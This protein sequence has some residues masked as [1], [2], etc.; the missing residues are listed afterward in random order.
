MAPIV[1]VFLKLPFIYLF[2]CFS[3]TIGEQDFQCVIR[4]QRLWSYTKE[5]L[6][7]VLLLQFKIV[8]LVLYFCFWKYTKSKFHWELS[9]SPLTVPFPTDRLHS[10]AF[11]QNY[12][13]RPAALVLAEV[14]GITASPEEMAEQGL[15]VEWTT[16]E[17]FS[18]DDIL[19][20]L[21]DDVWQQ[22]CE[23][24]LLLLKEC[25]YFS[26]FLAFLLPT[27]AAHTNRRYVSQSK[28]TEQNM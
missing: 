19:S 22:F 3:P 7:S 20:Y 26:F 13:E 23:E 14:P 8:N 9:A 27:A 15:Q 21:S 10:L 4:K 6:S 18:W 5:H 2:I 1:F 24:K 17:A 11:L 25:L 28:Q 16:I 12:H